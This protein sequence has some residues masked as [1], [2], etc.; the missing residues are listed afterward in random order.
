M[1]TTFSSRVFLIALAF[2]FDVVG[3]GDAAPPPAF[4]F[5]VPLAAKRAI[6]QGCGKGA[7]VGVGGKSVEEE[8]V[9]VGGE[10]VAR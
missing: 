1:S 10:G 4:R 3:D 7:C 8:G 6:A 2:F 5:R 9:G